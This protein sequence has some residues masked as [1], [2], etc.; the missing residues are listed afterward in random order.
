MSVFTPG[1]EGF[2]SIIVIFI[3][4]S[5]FSGFEQCKN[6][7]IKDTSVPQDLGFKSHH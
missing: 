7:G 3:S 5:C 2:P 6:D 4:G 1:K